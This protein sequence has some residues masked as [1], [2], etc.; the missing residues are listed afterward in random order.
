MTHRRVAEL[1]AKKYLGIS[2]IILGLL[3]TYFIGYGM[4]FWAIGFGGL[5]IVYGILM[6]F[7]YE[8]NAKVI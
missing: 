1:Y 6:Y 7:K 4:L 5:H 3:A 2:E 8:F